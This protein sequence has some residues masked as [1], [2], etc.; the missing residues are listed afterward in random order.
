MPAAL[1]VH[2]FGVFAGK[3]LIV[4]ITAIWLLWPALAFSVVHDLPRFIGFRFFDRDVSLGDNRV[5]RPDFPLLSFVIA[6]HL[7]ATRVLTMRS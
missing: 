5:T 2:T 4:A 7:M 3:G 1:A 6:N